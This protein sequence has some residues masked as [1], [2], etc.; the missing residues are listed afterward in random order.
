MHQRV[1][2]VHPHELGL[3]VRY[4]AA[5]SPRSAWVRP[6]ILSICGGMSV[7]GEVSGPAEALGKRALTS[8]FYVLCLQ[9]SSHGLRLLNNLILTRLLF[10]R[11]FGLLAIV[12]I[13]IEGM[14]MLSDVGVQLSII[15]SPRGGERTF[16]DTAWT[17]HV[18]RGA[19]MWLVLCALAWPA[20]AFY[21]EPDLLLLL[22]VAGLSTV[23][24]GFQSLALM[25]ANRDLEMR[26]VAVVELATQVGTAALTWWLAWLWPSVWVL[27][28]SLLAAAALRTGLSYAVFGGGH[29]FRWEATARAE[30]LAF[31]RFAQA[32]SILTFFGRQLDRLLLGKL[33]SM[34]E[35]GV[36][37]VAC[38]W[39]GAAS[40]VGADQA[41]KVG[42]PALA[43]AW[44]RD[45]RSLYARMRKLRLALVWPVA[46]GLCALA[47]VGE[48][49]I[50]GLYK[51][52]FHEAGWMLRVLA[53]GAICY[54]LNVSAE[55]VWVSLG[56]ANRMVQVNAARLAGRVCAMLLGWWL[57]GEV[58]L[59]LGVAATDALIYPL[60]SRWLWRRGLWQPE[61]DLPVLGVCYL[62]LA[63]AW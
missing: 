44:Q 57:Y 9:G 63:V 62:A 5:M 31:G 13:C 52:E 4:A 33:L 54:V 38:F 36:Y 53:A 59:V 16:L 37:N 23:V 28:F 15:K 32:S 61:V 39:A 42:I 27:A 24:D 46:L 8:A 30:I 14:R 35:L 21:G 55:V 43:E 11:A 49:L 60:L 58:G 34:R 48:P 19:C 22:P 56:Q 51:A 47:L 6:E 3:I 45:P 20:S 25:K 26:G 40:D 17:I 1:E 2:Q 12:N 50:R 41:I 29:R 10:E 7:A 18:V